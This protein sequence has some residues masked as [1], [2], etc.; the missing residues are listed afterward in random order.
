MPAI[1]PNTEKV[2]RST[3]YEMSMTLLTSKSN[4]RAAPGCD[5]LD[6]VESR[7]SYFFYISR[8]NL[9]MNYLLKLSESITRV[10]ISEMIELEG[11]EFY[12]ASPR[13]F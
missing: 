8:R 2:Q 9:I 1:S 12:G 13:T 5:T 11:Q 10:K 3:C 6:S 7:I 4:R